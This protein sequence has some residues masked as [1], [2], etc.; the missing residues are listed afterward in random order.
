[1]KLDQLQNNFSKH[2]L[3]ETIDIDA[4]NITGPFSPEQLLGL[5]RN[6]FY[7]SFRDYLQVCFPSVEALVGDEFFEQLTKAFTKDKSLES[8]SIEFYGEQFAGYIASCEQ[9]KSLPY[10]ADVAR[11][12]WAIDRAKSVIEFEEFSFTD[13]AQLNEQQQLDIVFSV[14]PNTLLMATQSPVFDIWC[15]IQKGDVSGIDM[16]QAQ[17]IVIFASSTKGAEYLS[18]SLAQYEF[19]S[20]V[21]EGASLQQLASIE[22]SQQH[23]QY[24]ISMALIINFR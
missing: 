22:D 7:M 15:G 20:A 2:L 5:Y 9:T 24:F 14:L 13:L 3:H 17:W 1:V 16:Q 23:L 8:A 21:V 6:N 4:L 11:F 10:L 19:L 12:D 18:L